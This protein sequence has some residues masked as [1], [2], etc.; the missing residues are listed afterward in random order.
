MLLFKLKCYDAEDEFNGI[1]QYI[2]ARDDSDKDYI[3]VISEYHI[4]L[5]RIL[6]RI[7]EISL[8]NLKQLTIDSFLNAYTIGKKIRI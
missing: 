5:S 2:M 4:S 3:M 6:E 7:M 8:D 1:K